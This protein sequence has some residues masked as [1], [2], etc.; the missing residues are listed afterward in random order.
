MNTNPTTNNSNRS[1][2][3]NL[4][5]NNTISGLKYIQNTPLILFQP[6]NIIVFFILGIISEYVGKIYTEI[7]NRPNFIIDEKTY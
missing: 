2:S 1:R 5:T 3:T 6:F 4:Y 7:K